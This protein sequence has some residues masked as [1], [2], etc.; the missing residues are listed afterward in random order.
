[1]LACR[2]QEEVIKKPHLSFEKWGSKSPYHTFLPSKAI[3]E[4]VSE[5]IIPEWAGKSTTKN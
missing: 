3:G 4:R 5:G 1:M 2:V